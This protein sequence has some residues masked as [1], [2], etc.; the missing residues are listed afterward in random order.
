LSRRAPELAPLKRQLS[1][2]TLR[3]DCGTGTLATQL[4]SA[5]EQCPCQMDSPDVSGVE[6]A[7][8]PSWSAACT[9]V[10]R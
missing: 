7:A 6:L 8:L 10:G 5:S 9:R 2:L 4:C 1:D 3:S